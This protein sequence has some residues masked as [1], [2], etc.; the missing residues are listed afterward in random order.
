MSN[1]IT[2][3]LLTGIVASAAIP[4]AVEPDPASGELRQWTVSEELLDWIERDLD[5]PVTLAIVTHFHD[6]SVGGTPVLAAQTIALFG[7][8]GD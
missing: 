3:A 5:L 1:I 6:D 2:I 4:R 8:D 7:D